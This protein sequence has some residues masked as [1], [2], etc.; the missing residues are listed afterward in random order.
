MKHLLLLIACLAAIVLAIAQAPDPTLL[1]IPAASGDGLFEPPAQWTRF[2]A[3]LALRH[4]WVFTLLTLIGFLRV[5]FKPLMAWLHSH[6]ES[7]ESTRDDAL[8]AQVEASIWYRI[9]AWLVDY[10][11]SIKLDTVK[12]AG[13]K[14]G[15]SAGTALAILL[16]VGAGCATKAPEVITTRIA[17][18]TNGLDV[19]S[20]KD[21]TFESLELED[22]RFGV[23][24]KVT[25]YSSTASAAALR[26]VEAEQTG[27]LAQAQLMQQMLSQWSELAARAYGIPVQPAQSV[28]NRAQ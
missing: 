5:V 1:V 11:G 26:S 14:S 3:E 16:M 8:L 4:P 12:K 9:G 21:I 7:T 19:V 6:V 15:A 22:P 24:A 2:I 28:T 17:Y 18:T 10:L 20:P 23:R 13:G 27:W 25:G